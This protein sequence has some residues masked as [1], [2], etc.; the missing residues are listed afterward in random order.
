MSIM[1]FV[2]SFEKFWEYFK[3]DIRNQIC[4][5]L[6]KILTVLIIAVPWNPYWSHIRE[7]WQQRHEKNF[8]FLFYEDTNNNLRN[9]IQTVA[10][11]L[12][13]SLTLEQLEKL[14]NHLKIENF[15]KNKAVNNEALKELGFFYEK[16]EGFIRRGKS[17]GWRDYFSEEEAKLA[18]KLVEEKEKEIGIKFKI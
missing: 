5:A 8:L 17:G 3:K 16:S 6:N 13:K 15:K 10:K 1:D 12:D 18:V 11:F 7:A 14:K 4:H 9:A 2:G